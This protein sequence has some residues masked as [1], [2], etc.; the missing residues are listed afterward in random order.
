M[1]N[2][3]EGLFYVN[4]LYQHGKYNSFV[5]TLVVCGLRA[6]IAKDS[7][8]SGQLHHEIFPHRTQCE[9]VVFERGNVRPGI[10]RTGP[11]GKI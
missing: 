5:F 8:V 2:D 1:E 10:R 4:E 3:L 11:N 7:A 6:C 9:F